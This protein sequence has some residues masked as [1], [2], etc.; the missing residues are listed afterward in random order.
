MASMCPAVPLLPP[1]GEWTVDDLELLP[2]DG[3]QYELIDGVLLVTP[4]PVRRHQRAVGELFAVLRAACPPQLEVLPAPIDFQPTRQRSL[5]PDLLVVPR[6]E[7][8]TI[9]DAPLL[10]VEVLSPSTRTKD[11]RFKRAVYADSGVRSYWVVDL[12]LPSVTVLRLA[13]DDYVDVATAAGSQ[14]L[15]AHEPFAATVVPAWLL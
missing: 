10:V 15:T 11:L 12:D 8:P 4:S 9:T 1:H 3:L 14:P 13:G 7:E 5:Q 2:D 6:S